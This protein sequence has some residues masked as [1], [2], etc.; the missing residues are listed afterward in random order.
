LAVNG[1]QLTSG[2]GAV[3]PNT[4]MALSGVGYVVLNEV[5]ATGDGV[6]SSALP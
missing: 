4:R 2:D 1:V 3:A 5:L 6:H